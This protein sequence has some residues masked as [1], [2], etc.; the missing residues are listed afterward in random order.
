MPK[1]E[2]A[3]QQRECIRGD[4]G[5][6]GPH[7]A[8]LA[9]GYYEWDDLR[10]RRNRALCHHCSREVERCHGL[11][12]DWMHSDDQQERCADG[13]I[14]LPGRT[15]PA[16]KVGVGVP[17]RLGGMSLSKERRAE[18]DRL[19]KIRRIEHE[20]A[21]RE[22]AHVEAVERYAEALKKMFPEGEA[23]QVSDGKGFTFLLWDCS[24]CRALVK[25]AGRETHYKDHSYL[26][27]V[28]ATASEAQSHHNLLR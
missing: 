12:G 18:D 8:K 11:H 19:Y 4:Q 7:G 10:E 14:A 5:H 21:A 20:A 27:Q 16:R 13:L 17:V 24:V 9:D 6:D 23:I 22:K 1:C 28:A 25:E 2:S 15:W 3:F 26:Q